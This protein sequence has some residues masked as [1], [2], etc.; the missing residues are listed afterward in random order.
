MKKV[1]KVLLV[2]W[3]VL[4]TFLL[5]MACIAYNEV[6]TEWS[7]KY[8]DLKE[9]SDALAKSWEEIQPGYQEYLEWKTQDALDVDTVLFESWADLVSEKNFVCAVDDKTVAVMVYA[10]GRSTKEITAILQ[11]KIPTY[12]VLLR[13]SDFTSSVLTVFGDNSEILFGYTIP[14]SGEPVT[15]ISENIVN[16]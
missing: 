9:K 8:D 3:A 2:V 15:F 13:S 16:K 5:V 12:C 7:A 4:A 1:G 10:E 14:S 6:D 11:E